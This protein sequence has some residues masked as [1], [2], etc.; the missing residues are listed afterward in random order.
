MRQASPNM[1]A[2]RFSSV[3]VD[4]VL[5]RALA[6][7]PRHIVLA[8]LLALWTGQAADLVLTGLPEKS[9]PASFFSS[10]GHCQRVFSSEGEAPGKI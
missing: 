7:A 5:E 6:A 4:L 10:P 9:N 3:L 2:R 8:I 1:P